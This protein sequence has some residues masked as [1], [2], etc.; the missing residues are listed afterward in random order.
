M[1]RPAVIVKTAA[2]LRVPPH[3]RDY[4]RERQ[5]D[6]WAAARRDLQLEA[7]GPM[8]MAVL[9]VDRHLQQGLADKTALRFV[10]RNAPALDMSYRTL[11][12]Q[13]NRLANV[14]Q[15][16]GVAPGDHL[17]VLAGRL[18]ALYAA[19]LGALK[20]GVVVTP[21]F[22]AF[23]PEPIA[24]RMQLGQ[25]RVLVTT[26][27][28]YRQK[29]RALRAQL[30]TLQHVL[31]VNPDG[32]P[33]HEPDTVDWTTVMAGASDQFTPAPTTADS[34]ALLHFTSGTTGTP[35]GAL[36]VHG[37]AITHYATGRHALDLHPQDRF[38]CTADPGWVTGTSYGILAP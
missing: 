37:A 36:H 6:P 21:L 10:A 26:D 28:L 27:I 29:I 24:T 8:N 38:W 33:T 12:Q 25:A 3:W 19:V 23:G 7:Q 31:L 4:Q 30:P 9:A 20:A 2:D 13:T 32:Q 16:L 22:S 11:A 17:F 15:A 1:D 5:Q 14:L 18:P 35:K 34:P